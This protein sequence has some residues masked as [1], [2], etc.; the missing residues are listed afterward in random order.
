MKHIQALP[1]YSHCLP[2]ESIQ[3]NSQSSSTPYNNPIASDARSQQVTNFILLR[4]S[5][6]KLP[7][8]LT[9]DLYICL[10]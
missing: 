8:L 4:S 7:L 10:F 6:I 9:Q 3:I 1:H 2:P 5:L